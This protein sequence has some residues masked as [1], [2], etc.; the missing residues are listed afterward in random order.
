MN[1][2]FIENLLATDSPRLAAIKSLMVGSLDNTSPIPLR[3][4]LKMGGREGWKE[5]IRGRE[6]G[7]SG[8]RKEGRQVMRGREGGKVSQLVDERFYVGH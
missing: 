6:G 4:S 3:A 8:G 1:W 2:S 7:R 5:G